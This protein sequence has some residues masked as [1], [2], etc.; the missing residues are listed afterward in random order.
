[1]S[2]QEPQRLRALHMDSLR[3]QAKHMLVVRDRH[4][5]WIQDSENIKINSIRR[6]IIDLIGKTVDQYDLLLEVLQRQGDG[7]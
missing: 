5:G 3:I 6:D 1:M 7:E 2:S 4:R